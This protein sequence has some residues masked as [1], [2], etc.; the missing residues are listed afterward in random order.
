[1]SEDKGNR[2]RA[3]PEPSGPPGSRAGQRET[4]GQ[5]SQGRVS[6]D[7]ALAWEREEQ[8]RLP[9]RGTSVSDPPS[10]AAERQPPEEAPT[11]GDE[12]DENLQVGGSRGP[13]NDNRGSR[14]RS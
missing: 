1:M 11:A 4:E 9:P 13:S 2:E 12:V 8:E 14:G 10:A 6:A 5:L 7:D 3:N